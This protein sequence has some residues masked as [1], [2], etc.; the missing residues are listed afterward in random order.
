MMRFFVLWCAVASV[1]PL[2]AQGA[3]KEWAVDGVTLSELLQARAQNPDKAQADLRRDFEIHY[4]N[5]TL[6]ETK[7]D[8]LIP[9]RH[10]IKVDSV[11]LLVDLL[12]ARSGVVVSAY[13]KEISV[14]KVPDTGSIRHVFKFTAQELEDKDMRARLYASGETIESRVMTSKTPFKEVL[15]FDTGVVS[16]DA[17]EGIYSPVTQNIARNGGKFNEVEGVGPFNYGVPYMVLND[18]YDQ[19]Q[20]D[21]EAARKRGTGRKV[22]V[23]FR[24]ASLQ[25]VNPNMPYPYE[26]TGIVVQGEGVETLRDEDPTKLVYDYEFEFKGKAVLTKK[27]YTGPTWVERK[28]FGKYDYTLATKETL[29]EFPVS[30]AFSLSRATKAG[31]ETRGRELEDPSNGN[32]PWTW[33][34]PMEMSGK[35]FGLYFWG[36]EGNSGNT[37]SF[38]SRGK[39]YDCPLKY[40]L[41]N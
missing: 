23:I 6:D 27:D 5:A 10:K 2:G 20:L 32:E 1:L 14:S 12:D 15:V 19:V 38:N 33:I 8:G 3:E 40:E 18:S 34:G 25:A 39:A 28:L 16:P 17:V 35:D 29:I 21:E 22:K 30:G 36:Y 9:S 31:V 7:P 41:Q 24:C 13:R 11:T 37:H 4:Q 26:V